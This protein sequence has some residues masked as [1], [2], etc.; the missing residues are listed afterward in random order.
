MADELVAKLWIEH[1]EGSFVRTPVPKKDIKFDKLGVAISS[2]IRNHDYDC[3]SF[4]SSRKKL[5]QIFEPDNVVDRSKTLST[6][7]EQLVQFSSN[8]ISV[9][10][11]F[12]YRS[13]LANRILVE[14]TEH[15]LQS[16]LFEAPVQRLNLTND[17]ALRYPSEG[18]WFLVRHDQNILTLIH[19]S[20][21]ENISTGNIVHRKVTFLTSN[22]YLH[23]HDLMAGATGPLAPD[24]I[25][26]FNNSHNRNISRS[27]YEALRLSHGE[28]NFHPPD[29]KFL[30]GLLTECKVLNNFYFSAFSQNIGET[31]K[32]GLTD[33]HQSKSQ[34]A[35]CKLAVLLQEIIMPVPDSGTFFFYIGDD[36][37]NFLEN[38]EARRR[39]EQTNPS[40]SQSSS[41]ESDES[42]YSE[43]MDIESNVT[44][45]SVL[46]NSEI[47]LETRALQDQS[48]PPVFIRF[49][50]G[51]GNNAS[52]DD[53]RQLGRRSCVIDA[54]V[55][56][57][58]NTTRI[59]DDSFPKIDIIDNLKPIHRRTSLPRLHSAVA[60]QVENRFKS[61]VAEQTLERLHYYSDSINETEV[62]MIT[63]CFMEAQSVLTQ[64]I[65]IYLYSITADGIVA[66]STSSPYINDF[67]QGR[68]TI[69]NSYL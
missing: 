62:K 37:E 23:D 26:L 67:E 2:E 13:D 50:F 18:I 38:I 32:E 68:E 25:E 20:S 51:D 49:S 21:E 58:S 17:S 40:Y 27:A 61:V 3:A 63:K 41:P 59:V 34:T 46:A 56:V 24:I 35:G 7:V 12:F 15:L 55:S 8:E 53:I 5:L 19:F 44:D 47:V 31:G 48:P 9:D 43:T 64:Y 22:V 14:R 66:A 54:F 30:L 4:L 42:V 36:S 10:L 29:L 45:N 65:P 57:F 28:I 33:Y 11:R 16:A 52:L 60:I 6:D 39:D 69:H 1:K